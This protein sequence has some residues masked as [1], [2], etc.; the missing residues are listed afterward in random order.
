[1]C[2]LYGKPACKV[3]DCQEK[4]ENAHRRPIGWVSRKNNNESNGGNDV[5]AASIDVWE[6]G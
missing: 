3:K 4:E 5:G 6:F 1:M 2:H